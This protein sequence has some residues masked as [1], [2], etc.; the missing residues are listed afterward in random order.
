[1][2][3]EVLTAFSSVSEV[4]LLVVVTILLAVLLIG[5]FF[6]L[7]KARQELYEALLRK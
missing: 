6:Q 1:M 7:D 2:I 5:T 4:G 3:N